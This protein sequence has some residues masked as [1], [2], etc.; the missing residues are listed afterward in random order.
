MEEPLAAAI[1]AGMDIS[2]PEGI[3]VMDIGGGTTDIA[4]IALG[5]IIASNSVKVAGDKFDESIIKYMRKKH[6][7]YIGEKRWRR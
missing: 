7:L 5:G 4:I 3:M 6:K 2:K 1:G